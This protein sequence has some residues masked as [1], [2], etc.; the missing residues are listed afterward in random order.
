MS[1]KTSPSVVN[2]SFDEMLNVLLNVE[3][4][5]LMSCRFVTVPDMNKGGRLSKTV[6]EYPNKFLGR[7]KKETSGTFTCGNSYVDRVKNQ[8][9]KDGLDPE[10]WVIEPSKVGEH[11][12][13]C[14]TYNENTLNHCFQMEIHPDNPHN[15]V[16]STF[17]V[18]GQRLDLTNHI[19][20]E[21]FN[22]FEE[23]LVKKT[24]PQKQLSVGITD[25]VILFSPSVKNIKEITLN[26]VR[27]VLQD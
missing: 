15:H 2:V 22:K 8:M 26:H 24:L 13:K 21:I 25:P 4:G 6:T 5:Q 3:K 11:V 12:S 20:R 18:D 10:S 7:V 23:Y 9:I 16:K 19:D 27:Y 17:I 1:T 14:V